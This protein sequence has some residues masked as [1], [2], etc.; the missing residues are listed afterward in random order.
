[1][2]LPPSLTAGSHAA[3]RLRL[4]TANAPWPFNYTV[5]DRGPAIQLGDDL[6]P[7]RLGTCGR[8]SNCMNLGEAD[9]AEAGH[10]GAV[11]WGRFNQGN[12]R[13]TLLLVDLN[14]QLQQASGIHYLAGIPTVTMPTTGTA[15][16]S[17]S[18]ATAP[19]FARGGTDPGTFTGQGLVHFAPG[20]GTQVALDGEL[21]FGNGQHYRMTTSGA[22]FD[23]QGR[24]S[25]VGTTDL[26][27]QSPSTFTGN[28]NVRSLGSSDD[29]KCGA[30]DCRAAV[31]G[32][33]FGDDAGQMGFGYT[34][35]NPKHSSQT[36][37][38]HGVAVMK[39]E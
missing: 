29:M 25:Q 35:T 34:V 5:T 2:P 37:T 39:R 19:T 9:T 22:Q 14:N 10:E 26:R 1:M 11:T 4:I 38:I 3:G 23:A 16:Y 27:M 17:L 30:G 28:L 20:T 18:G 36:D 8:F 13:L 32:G 12:A 7:G 21:R 33:F 15:R 24:L 6:R 31:N